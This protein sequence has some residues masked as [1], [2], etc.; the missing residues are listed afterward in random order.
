VQETNFAERSGSY[1]GGSDTPLTHEL[2]FLGFGDGRVDETTATLAVHQPHALAW[3]AHR[4]LL[5]VAG[6]GDDTILQ[7]KNAS[8]PSVAGGFRSRLTAKAACGPDGLAIAPS[9]DVLVWCSF[10]RTVE[11]I[12]TTASEGDDPVRKLTAGPELVASAMTAKQHEG[13]VLFHVAD[14]RISENGHLACASC[15]PDNRADGLSWRIEKRALQTPLLAGRL[16]GTHPFKWDGTDPTLRAS[17]HSTMRRLGGTGLTHHETDA[18]AAYLEATPSPRA[19]TRD[20]AQVARGKQL[21][22]AEG[23]KSCHDGPAYTDRERHK[24]TGSLPKSDTPSLVG[25][26]ASAPYF[27]DGSAATLEALLRDRG[28]VHGMADTARLSDPQIVDL[29]AYLETL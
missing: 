8:Q 28:A 11:R 6:L 23:C 12:A 13:L 29:T 4:D 2:A 22:D 10:T 16:V 26:A 25:L 17:L 3:D 27:H 14:S 15:H 9:G 20:A 1:G 21:F 19:P 18:L 5:Y 24:F 7:I